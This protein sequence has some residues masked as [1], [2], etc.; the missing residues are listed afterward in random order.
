MKSSSN[1]DSSSKLRFVQFCDFIVKL[2]VSVNMAGGG[3]CVKALS[4]GV[5]AILRTCE[6]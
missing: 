4:I 3:G 2:E 5:R 6:Q 1:L